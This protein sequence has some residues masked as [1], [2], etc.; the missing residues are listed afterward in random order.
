VNKL[1]LRK[2]SGFTLVELVAVISI[3]GLLTG[4]VTMMISKSLQGS[5]RLD[6]IRALDSGSKMVFDNINR[7]FREGTIES[8]VNLTGDVK[9]R[10]DCLTQG[11][12]T[13]KT[14]LVIGLDGNETNL[15]VDLDGRVAS[16][17]GAISSSDISISNFRLVWSCMPAQPDGIEIS[18][19]ASVLDDSGLVVYGP[20]SYLY[21]VVARN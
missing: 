1:R 9:D 17:S 20:R 16:N 15:S 2:V 4:V 18:F 21:Q 3:L 7:L 19:D 11:Q 14:A 5:K 12:V 10:Q 6:Y 13:A 8:V